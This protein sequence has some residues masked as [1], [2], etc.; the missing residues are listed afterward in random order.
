MLRRRAR[1]LGC[2]YSVKSGGQL[3]VAVH[4][5]LLSAYWSGQGRS[6]QVYYSA[7][8]WGHES[9]ITCSNTRTVRERLPSKR[10]WVCTRARATWVH[11][12]SRSRTIVWIASDMARHN[13]SHRCCSLNEHKAVD[14]R[15]HYHAR[16]I[17]DGLTHVFL[18]CVSGK[19]PSR[20][21]SRPSP[22]ST[23]VCASDDAHR[24]QITPC[25]AGRC[26]PH[27]EYG[28]LDQWRRHKA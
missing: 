11:G 6:G 13:M 23:H 2:G 25:A 7:K 4:A 3:D 26:D 9:G 28:N 16:I 19:T 24:A 12:N 15:Y 1:Q 18:G 10:A 21:S 27:L 20:Q 8:I 22:S 14:H 5:T 17:H